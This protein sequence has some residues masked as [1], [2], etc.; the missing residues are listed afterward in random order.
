[1]LP[2]SRPQ[3]AGAGLP[4]GLAAWFALWMVASLPANTVV[5]L[6]GSFFI[7]WFAGA[8]GRAQLAPFTEGLWQGALCFFLLE[9]GLMAARQLR[10][11]GRGLAPALIGFGL[12]MPLVGAAL[13]EYVARRDQRKAL[14]VGVST[15][16]GIMAGLIAKVV[17]AFV[18]IGI[19]VVAL[20]V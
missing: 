20:L 16:L 3:T 6:L 5:L 15:W 14:H 7:G 9:M 17:L 4:Q 1:M 19:F 11:A 2:R 8:P 18:M 12:L 13:G 10:A